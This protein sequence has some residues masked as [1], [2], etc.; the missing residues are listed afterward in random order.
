MKLNNE[1]MTWCLVLGIGGMFL[2]A[3]SM[4]LTLA[5]VLIAPLVIMN[6]IAWLIG[7]LVHCRTERKKKQQ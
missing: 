7:K 1:I 3:P 5:V 6:G 4:M 2:A